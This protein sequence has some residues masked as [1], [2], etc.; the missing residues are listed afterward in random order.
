MSD[1]RRILGPLGMIHPNIPATP[2]QQQQ[3]QPPPL[4]PPPFPTQ[5]HPTH[6]II[7]NAN[8]SAYL[9]IANTILEV[10]IFGP[11]PIRGSFID[12]ATL[13][14]ECKFLPHI[15]PQPQGAVFNDGTTK[16]T[17]TGMTGV[18]H[19]LS[20]YLETCFLP[21]LVLEK[22]PKSSIDIQVSIISVDRELTE[23]EW[24]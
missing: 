22:Y 11:R 8:G 7:S 18:E 16:N 9:E 20:S 1:R 3:Q 13:S 4:P 2:Q 10:S 12:R 15:I 14:I 21:C 17:R 24:E 5:R 23:G 19:R 6:G